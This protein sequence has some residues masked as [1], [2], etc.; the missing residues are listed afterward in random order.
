V[1]KLIPT[2]GGDV[3]ILRTD[4]S[5]STYAVGKVSK[6][7][8][9]DFHSQTNVKYVSDRA[10]AEAEAKALVVRGRRIFL[11]NL[12]TGDWSEIAS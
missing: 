9:Q 10:A 2:K 11:W 6:D 4:Q 3:L 12:D 8:Q 5:F 1:A 7:G